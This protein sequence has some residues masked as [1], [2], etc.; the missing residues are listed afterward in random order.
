MTMKTTPTLGR[1]GAPLFLVAAACSSSAG[2][3]AAVDAGAEAEGPLDAGSDADALSNATPP[4]P[5]PFT[6]ANIP[7]PDFTGTGN[8]DI[9][10]PCTIDTDQ[11]TIS[12]V[13]AS[14]PPFR[15]AKTAQLGGAGASAVGLFV[16]S[17]IRVEPSAQVSV[18]GSQPLVMVAS[19]TLD[20]LGGL[21]ASAQLD[22]ANAG[23]YA[24]TASGVGGGPGGGDATQANYDA[25]GGGGYC[26]A[27]GAGGVAVPPGSMG[28]KPYG[29]P[30]LVPL[31]GGSA[32]G[33]GM[34]AGIG[35]SGGAG[36]GAVQLVAGTEITIAAGGFVN[37]G[38]G[39]G[40]ANGGAGGSGGAILIEA[41][42][43][44]VAGT[45][46]ANGGGGAV[47]NGGAPGQNGQP[48][49]MPANGSAPTAGSG[50]AG[51]TING[52]NGAITSGDNNSSGGGGGGAGRI[53]ID[54]T[55]GA[56]SITGTLSPDA[57]T[58][59]VSQ[60]KLQTH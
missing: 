12:C 28:G 18:T 58:A 1:F 47:F 33:G 3:T 15:F 57:S 13:Q 39:G 55:T 51:A 48:R 20:V 10:G 21:D 30:Q 37:A 2:T 29:T 53:R 34:P 14:P 42:T 35:N 41:P 22:A 6:P 8:L 56:A 17:S 43:V 52:G 32:G 19:T 45:L 4:P 54:T 27:G 49:A 5:L 16:A 50:S 31:V 59:C 9:S 11:G 7:S 24:Q 38:G 25:A 36:G 46:A 23:G 44:T 40:R 26:G 60:G